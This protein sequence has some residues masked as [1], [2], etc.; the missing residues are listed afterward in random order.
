MITDIFGRTVTASAPDDQGQVTYTVTGENAGFTVTRA[1]SVPLEAIM[2]TIN[3]MAP[4][5]R[6][7]P[8]RAQ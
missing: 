7:R 3:A 6:R 2:S 8:I 1:A 4:E 5:P